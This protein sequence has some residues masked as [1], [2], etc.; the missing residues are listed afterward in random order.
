MAYHETIL[1]ILVKI[2]RLGKASEANKFDIGIICCFINHVQSSDTHC[3]IFLEG[4][5]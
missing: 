4:K 3:V 1:N 2:H 5:F